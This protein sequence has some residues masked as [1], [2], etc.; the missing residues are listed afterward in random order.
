MIMITR[1]LKFEPPLTL[2]AI[3]FFCFLAF[4]FAGGQTA[5]PELREFLQ[6]M[7]DHSKAVSATKC[8]TPACSV[9]TVFKIAFSVDLLEVKQR[10]IDKDPKPEE[11]SFKIFNHDTDALEL[12]EI[13]PRP[14]IDLIYDKP[15]LIAPD[16]FAVVRLSYTPVRPDTI[17]GCLDLKIKNLSSNITETA[18]LPYRGIAVAPQ[19]RLSRDEIDFRY[20]HSGD[21]KPETLMISNTGDTTLNVSYKIIG[22]SQSAFSVLQPEDTIRVAAKSDITMSLQFEPSTNSGEYEADLVLQSDTFLKKERSLTVRLKGK[23]FVG[24]GI[25]FDS[26]TIHPATCLGVTDTIR[27]AVRN[28]GREILNIDS[29]SSSDTLVFPMRIKQKI[30]LAPG[31]ARILPFSFAPQTAIN[32]SGYYVA[33]TNKAGGVDTLHVTGLGKTA[34]FRVAPSS[35]LLQPLKA[36]VNESAEA[37]FYIDNASDCSL[38]I[39]DITVIPDMML[40]K[41]SEKKATIPARGQITVWVKY[42]PQEVRDDVAQIVV[43]ARYFEETQQFSVVGNGLLGAVASIEPDMLN[44]GEVCV[45]KELP[46]EVKVSN[47]GYIAFAIDAI[48]TG[49]RAF[50]IAPMPTPER[51]IIIGEQIFIVTYA[52]TEEQDNE[53]ATFTFN[54]PTAEGEKILHVSGK[55]LAKKLALSPIRPPKLPFGNVGVAKSLCDTVRWKNNSSGPITITDIEIKPSEGFTTSFEGTTTIASGETFA[56]EVCFQPRTPKYYYARLELKHDTECADDTVALSG[57]GCA[58]SLEH[59][60]AAIVFDPIDYCTTATFDTGVLITGCETWHLDSTKWEKDSNFTVCAIPNEVPSGDTLRLR[61]CFDPKEK[62]GDFDDTLT[63]YSNLYPNKVWE[64][65]LRANARDLTAPRILD[66]TRCQTLTPRTDVPITAVFTDRCDLSPVLDDTLFYRRI[67]RKAEWVLFDNTGKAVIPGA[68]V[69]ER[70]I[71]YRIKAV[72]RS[73]NFAYDPPEGFRS[74][75][76]RVEAPESLIVLRNLDAQ[77]SYFPTGATVNSYRM[78]SVPFDLEKKHA[79]DVIVDDLPKYD[80]GKTWLLYDYINGNYCEY[81]PNA[82]LDKFREFRPGRAFWLISTAL[83]NLLQ[84]G[85]GISVTT[86]PASAKSCSIEDYSR[87]PLEPGWNLIGNPYPFNIATAECS[88]KN[89]D[90]LYPIWSYEV[91]PNETAARWKES[92]SVLEPWKGYA[93]R[94]LKETE[95]IFA[96]REVGAASLPRAQARGEDE[97]EDW[98]VTIEAHAGEHADLDNYAGVREYALT[99][100]DA[101]DVFEPPP[102]GEYVAVYFPHRD[103]PEYPSDYAGDFR[104]PFAEGEVWEFEVNSNLKEKKILLSIKNGV[105]FPSHLSVYLYDKNRQAFQNLRENANY[106]FDNLGELLPGRFELFIGTTDFVQHRTT[107]ITNNLPDEIQ[108][109]QNF[110]NPFNQET[111]FSFYLPQAALVTLKVFDVLGREVRVL[112]EGQVWPQGRQFVRWGGEDQLHGR[113]SSGIYILSLTAKNVLKQKRVL[114]V[115]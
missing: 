103:W 82:P 30:T 89:G 15:K 27:V 112:S 61:I 80:N 62:Q 37:P 114:V 83:P 54:A 11:V 78:I 73:R 28:I 17:C 102:I 69:T 59:P 71:E 94:A 96:T 101:T 104:P 24:P 91:Q 63:I 47:L 22:P 109:Y 21:Q 84:V 41:V 88:L 52:P 75:R 76:V 2:S 45:G 1:R 110:P 81:T 40:F 16:S 13:T 29:I 49:S 79:Q 53:S 115:E 39:D 92:P 43:R 42:K 31:E 20:V 95:L 19:I 25:A 108:L 34:S 44:F 111:I 14:Q 35:E 98:R 4:A 6:D 93:I 106:T 46:L 107:A 5:H 3:P 48:T 67:G 51:P 90:P 99:T 18:H 58:P 23:S 87:Y 50:R 10:V 12:I 77:K 113:V 68:S 60:L 72:D 9:T 36:V 56:P 86:S 8:K 64:I 7:S 32:Y 85:Q 38:F 97:T 66:T 26:T 33:H 105:S 74:L 55:S 70:G 65:A 100:W 57:T